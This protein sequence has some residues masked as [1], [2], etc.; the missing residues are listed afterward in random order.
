MWKILAYNPK[1]P[2]EGCWTLNIT[3]LLPIFG[4]TTFRTPDN[5]I[6]VRFQNKEDAIA[7]ISRTSK[8]WN[9]LKLVLEEED[10]SVTATFTPI[11]VFK[12]GQEREKN[13]MAIFRYRKNEEKC[14]KSRRGHL[15]YVSQGV[16][17]EDGLSG[18]PQLH[19]NV[20]CESC[21]Q[22][23]VV[24]VS[25]HH[26]G[27]LEAANFLN[28][29]NIIDRDHLFAQLPGAQSPLEH[30]PYLIPLVPSRRPIRVSKIKQ[31]SKK[32]VS[33]VF[34]PLR[35]LKY[36]DPARWFGWSCGDRI[37]RNIVR[38]IF[39]V[40][41]ILLGI[42]VSVVNQR[43]LFD[44]SIKC[45]TP[46]TVGRS[47]ALVNTVKTIGTLGN[48]IFIETEHGDQIRCVL[49]QDFGIPVIGDKFWICES[50]YYHKLLESKEDGLPQ[51]SENRSSKSKASNE[52]F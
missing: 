11:Q 12:H 42:V 8:Y 19:I 37:D 29:H 7:A 38:G 18:N 20:T 24:I 50:G 43:N 46:Q 45:N 2:R 6:A 1:I 32:L 14:Q 26:N 33:I 15:W 51:S 30:T 31:F 13:A 3:A 48:Y 22:T 21:L 9:Y 23:D 39:I 34:F 5:K 41:A 36:L 16:K 40:G 27:I 4:A 44:L 10:A 47:L 52:N 49:H 28:Q 17:K 25:T 35:P